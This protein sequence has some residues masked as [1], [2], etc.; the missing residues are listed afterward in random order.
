LSRARRGNGCRRRSAGSPR[1]RPPELDHPQ[2][3]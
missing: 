3:V 2:R 1:S